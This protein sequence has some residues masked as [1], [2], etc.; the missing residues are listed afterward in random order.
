MYI[1]NHQTATSLCLVF[2]D[3]KYEDATEDAVLLFFLRQTCA[4]LS[5][6]RGSREKRDEYVNIVMSMMEMLYTSLVFRSEMHEFKITTKFLLLHATVYGERDIFWNRAAPFQNTIER[7]SLGLEAAEFLCCSS[8]QID[9]HGQLRQ[10]GEKESG[11]RI[12]SFIISK[13][14]PYV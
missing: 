10:V 6:L 1:Q 8:T 12:W 7:E 9:R 3:C 14:V 13:I 4:L 2:R 11:C 5:G